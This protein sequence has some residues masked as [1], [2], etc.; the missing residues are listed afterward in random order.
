MF[1]L[2][3]V[4]V[5]TFVYMRVDICMRMYVYLLFCASIATLA[6]LL[7]QNTRENMKKGKEKRKKQ[8][9]NTKT[10]QQQQNSDKKHIIITFC[11]L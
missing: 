3:R 8:K 1:V 5:S 7:A 11:M 4:C 2:V 6:T 10:Q 9:V